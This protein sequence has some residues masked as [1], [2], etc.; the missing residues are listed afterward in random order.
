MMFDLYQQIFLKSKLD[1][2]H[3]RAIWTEAFWNVAENDE[4]VA[5]RKLAATRK[6]RA[7]VVK[8]A[9][10]DVGLPIGYEYAQS[11]FNR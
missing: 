3:S 8:T 7:S 1:F 4:V 9:Y 6:L 2:P 11:I 10:V 5:L